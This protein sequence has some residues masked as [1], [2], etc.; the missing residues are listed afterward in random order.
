MIK[1]GRTRCYPHALASS[2]LKTF[3]TLEGDGLQHEPT[4]GLHLGTRKTRVH[5]VEGRLF[6]WRLPAK[7]LKR[8]PAKRKLSKGHV[9]SPAESAP[10]DMPARL[11]EAQGPQQMF[12]RRWGG[13][14]TDPVTAFVRGSFQI[15]VSKWVLFCVANEAVFFLA[16]EEHRFVQCLNFL[17]STL[18]PQIISYDCLFFSIFYFLPFFEVLNHRILNIPTTL[19]DRSVDNR[20]GNFKDR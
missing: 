17:K 12:G 19:H 15:L 14:P 20:R 4:P 13:C 1:P 8:F 9:P 16:L 3:K 5:Q 2:W 7:A 11:L 6:E 18:E 10:E